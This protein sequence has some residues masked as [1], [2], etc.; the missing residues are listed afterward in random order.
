[1]QPQCRGFSL[2]HVSRRDTI[3]RTDPRF[4]LKL[5]AAHDLSRHENIHDN[6]KLRA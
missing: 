4:G 2:A 1:M 5:Q 6:E 3:F